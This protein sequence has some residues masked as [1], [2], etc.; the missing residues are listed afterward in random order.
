VIEGIAFMAEGEKNLYDSAD[1][2][3]QL[4]LR[5][6][7]GDTHA[8]V[9]LHAVLVPLLGDFIASFDGQLSPSDRDDLVQE[10]IA[11]IWQRLGDYRGNA[12]AKTFA[13]AITRNITLKHISKRQRLP[14]I[15]AADVGRIL[16]ERELYE[17]ADSSSMELSEDEAKL[18]RAMNELTD[19]QR[20]A[21]LLSCS[22]DSRSTAARK[23]GCTPSQFADRLH[24]AKKR[25]RH[26][27]NGVVRCILL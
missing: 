6:Q 22:G 4:L 5:A 2:C 12:S 9:K 26:M 7:K 20:Q 14:M 1:P 17:Q 27:L 24:Y 8:F 3:T 25:L 15:H 19:V 23:A 21:V 10:S 16:D 11:A 18:R 13:L